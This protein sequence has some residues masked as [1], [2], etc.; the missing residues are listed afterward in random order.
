MDN[1]NVFDIVDNLYYNY[2]INLSK[3]VSEY[4]SAMIMQCHKIPWME[5]VVENNQMDPE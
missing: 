3:Y 5:A 1:G 2:H 4:R